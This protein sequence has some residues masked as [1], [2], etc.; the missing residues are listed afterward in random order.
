MAHVRTAEDAA[1][2]A[3]SEL[4]DE[5]GWM[6]PGWASPAAANTAAAPAPA[7]FTASTAPRAF[8][9]LKRT[10]LITI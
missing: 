1:Q 5:P 9:P 4:D 2:N 6:Y 3:V 7:A 8:P 10:D